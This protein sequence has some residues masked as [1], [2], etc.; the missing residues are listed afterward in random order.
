MY[1][2]CRLY[3]WYMLD[4]HDITRQSRLLFCTVKVEFLTKV[5]NKN[6]FIQLVTFMMEADLAIFAIFIFFIFFIFVKLVAIILDFIKAIF[7]PILCFI[8]NVLNCL[9]AFAGVLFVYNYYSP[10][11]LIIYLII[12]NCYTYEKYQYDKYCSWRELWRSQE[13]ALLLCSILGGWLGAVLAQQF[14]RHKTAK[15]SFQFEHFIGMTANIFLIGILSV[16]NKKN[17]L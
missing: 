14:C 12:I 10:L 4:I 2:S 11:L 8:F 5:Q 9:T 3:Q 16:L 6:H 1:N 13:D 15:L 7:T 17:V